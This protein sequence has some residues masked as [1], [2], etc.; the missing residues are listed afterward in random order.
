[1]ADAGTRTGAETRRRLLGAAATAFAHSGYHGT[2]TAEIAAAAGVSEPTLFKHFGSKQALL[3][4]ALQ[5]TAGDLMM[6]LDA[7]P[8]PG[9]DPFETFVSRTRGL[10][11]D[12][13]LAQLSRLRNFA[14]AL[15][16]E[17]NLAG[18]G[19]ELDRFLN[20]I[21]GAIALGQKTGAVRKDVAPADVSELVLALSLLFGFRSALEGDGPAADRLSSVVDTL[22]AM[23]R[24]PER[25]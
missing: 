17:A 15:T 1:M 21:A 19:S 3:V 24:A 16:D 10:L 4:A 18:L 20:Q 11:A 6:V 5:Q 13:K 7:P 8:D 12:P 23:L 14:L 25:S 2:A 9:A 22:L